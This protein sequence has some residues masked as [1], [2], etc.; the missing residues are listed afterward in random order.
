MTLVISFAV[1]ALFVFQSGRQNTTEINQHFYK[2]INERMRQEVYLEVNN[3]VDE[4]EYNLAQIF[5]VEKNNLRRIIHSQYKLLQTDNLL[6]I[7]DFDTRRNEALKVYEK[8]ALASPEYLFFVIDTNGNLL[9]SGSNSAKEGTNIYDIKDRDGTYFTQELIEAKNNPDGVFVTY[10]WPKVSDGEPLKKTSYS[11]YLEEFDIVIGVGVYL[12]DVEAKLKKETYSRLQDFYL[13]EENYVFITG[14]DGIAHVFADQSK[15]GHSVT[16]VYDE[17][18]VNIFDGFMNA[19]KDSEDG[20]FTYKYRK[21]DSNIESE[22]I[23]YVKR[24]DEWNAFIGMGYH[25]DDILH[26]LNTLNEEHAKKNLIN[27]LITIGLLFVTAFISLK[28]IQRGITL[29]KRLQEQEEGAFKELFELAG[30]GI[31]ILDNNKEVVYS[32]AKANKLVGFNFNYYIDL[33]ESALSKSNERVLKLEHK[34]SNKNFYVESIKKPI[35]YLGVDSTLYLL[36]DVTSMY[37]EKNELIN[38][39]LL[40][41]LTQIANRR[42]LD[43]DLKELKDSN[44]QKVIAL[45]DLDNFKDV[46]DNY[47]HAVG[48]KTLVLLAKCFKERLRSGDEIYRYGGEEFVVI[49]EGAT[50]EAA[51]KVLSE[52]NSLLNTEAKDTLGFNITFSAGVADIDRDI[53]ASLEQVD[54]LLYKAKKNGKNLIEID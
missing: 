18:G 54:K 29:Q 34:T 38:K 33:H 13:G 36:K 10:Y 12:E 30:E 53:E 49:F 2:Y 5:T 14:Y 40:D 50:K 45:I 6:G 16:E 25:T 23:S 17:D 37:L 3:R 21:P 51:K 19:I 35:V 27:L 32:N 22:K 48:D 26:E 47:G 24:L 31:L 28:I 44:V 39:A 15:I 4:I 11:L 1:I 7:E 52:V 9:K 41:Q 42:K 20:Y 43:E 8:I 46:N